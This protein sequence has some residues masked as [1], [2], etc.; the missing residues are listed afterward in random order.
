MTAVSDQEEYQP[1]G[2]TAPP[3]VHEVLRS[4]GVPLDADT[5]AA[6][7][8]RFGEDFSRI[9]VH[10]DDRAARSA[11]AVGAR[12]YTVGSNVVFGAGEYQPR[13]ASGR[14]LLAHELAHAATQ[15]DAPVPADLPIGAPDHPS[16]HVARKASAGGRVVG[17]RGPAVLRRSPLTDEL[18]R[19]LVGGVFDVLRA[20]GKNGP[21]PTD[22]DLVPW[23]DKH[24]PRGSDERWLA[25]QLIAHGAEPRWPAAT[26]AERERR[27]AAGHLAP[28]AGNIEATFDVGAGRT[29]IQAFYFPGRTTRHA[30]IV[31]GVHGSEGAGI[32]V[33]ELLLAMLRTPDSQGKV[34]VPEFSVIVVP[35]LFPENF[36][37]HKRMAPDTPDPNRRLPTVG[38]VVGQEKDRQGRPLDAEKRPLPPEN[39]VLL[40]LVDRFQPERIAMVHGVSNADNPN[41]GVSTDPRPGYDQP[42]RPD[43]KTPEGDDR[44]LARAMGNAAIAKGARAPLNA[45]GEVIYP[46]DKEPHEPG[47]T[48]GMYGSRAAGP[49]PAMNVILIEPLTNVRSDQLKGAAAR[50]RKVELQAF[51]TVLRDIFLERP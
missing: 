14:S 29:P 48:F 47:T 33:V 50:D 3:V 13:S 5:E 27:A 44:A 11:A 4:S 2:R 42:S 36:A 30:M 20:R 26:F 16:E 38:T 40:D 32:E 35:V 1:V 41:A 10:A 9:R 18:S 34:R 17:D 46:T 39:L 45:R 7:G 49:R 31:G 24:L 22:P 43:I 28:D 21:I 37:Q 23:L 15:V 25:D 19:K 51:A 8:R 6:M 12:A